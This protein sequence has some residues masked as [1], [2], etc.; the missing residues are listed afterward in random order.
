MRHLF[1]QPV[2]LFERR[3]L[4]TLVSRVTSDVESLM[5]TLSS[6][7]VTI[8]S[9]SLLLFGILVAMSLMSLPLTVATLV[10]A[11][12][13]GFVINFYR[14]K[15]R[16]YYDRIRQ[17]TGRMNG[18]VNEA[19]H[20]LREVQ[21]FSYERPMQQRFAQAN[22]DFFRDIMRVVGFEAGLYSIVEGMGLLSIA[23]MAWLGALLL[24]DQ[25]ISIGVLVAFITYIQ[26]FYGPIKELSSK[27]ATLQSGLAALERLFALL[28]RDESRPWGKQ[29]T[30]GFRP[31]V[32]FEH[33]WFVYPQRLQEAQ[34]PRAF[35]S[36]GESAGE[37][38]VGLLPGTREVAD[39]AGWPAAVQA[40]C[41]LKDISF[42]IEPGERVALV[43][44]TG[45]GKSTIVKLI[46]GLYRP[47]RGQVRVHGHRVTD[48]ERVGYQ[49]RVG[50]VPQEVH[51]FE[52]SVAFNIHFDNP[53]ITAEQV[54]EAC[55]I[56]Q[57][58]A[59]IQALPRGY[60]TV[61]APGG[62]NLSQGQRQLLAFAR[63]LAWAPDLVILD[64]ATASVDAHAEQMLQAAVLEVLKRKT[65]LVIA[66]RLATIQHCDRILVMH[67]GRLVEQGSHTQLLQRPE[68][69]YRALYQAQ[70]QQRV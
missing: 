10:V 68:G 52:A 30:A 4:G 36:A 12:P 63:V 23:V 15:L 1:Q 45:S 60:E 47:T 69:Y 19:A 28:D 13:V 58:D 51:L 9:D 62:G 61:L 59:F 32:A 2:A 70:F 33:V 50:L 42:Q 7:V 53:Q 66:H 39:G 55:R 41:A 22:T 67:G 40:I 64:E 26:R 18:I 29:G 37:E 27:M 3:P 8:L 31:A 16:F 34:Q 21:L 57:A 65:T 6:G 46:T 11:I 35:A 20:G 56:V 44:L 43:G 25:Q 24:I 48:Y 38:A 5:E 49:Q 14:G 17:H 54:V